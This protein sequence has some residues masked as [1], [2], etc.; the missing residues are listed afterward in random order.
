MI[1]PGATVSANVSA[2]SWR[3]RWGKL[4]AMLG[5]TNLNAALFLT[6]PIRR[7]V[8]WC[9]S[10]L[11]AA[12]NL[13]SLIAMAAMQVAS[14]TQSLGGATKAVMANMG[15]NQEANA[16]IVSVIV[17][18]V[19]AVL[20]LVAMIPVLFGSLSQGNTALQNESLTT[21]NAEADLLIPILSLV[22]SFGG[23]LLVLGFVAAA[24]KFKRGGM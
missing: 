17:G 21:G 24:V 11:K 23:I 6:L 2:R 18:A 10:M 5:L 4:V 7:R 8:A 12:R 13:Q 19:I 3:L 1:V 14:G 20:I 15:L 22:L 9:Q 16:A